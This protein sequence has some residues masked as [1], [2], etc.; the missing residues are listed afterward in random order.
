MCFLLLVGLY[1]WQLDHRRAPELCYF[2]ALF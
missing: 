2:V 1:G